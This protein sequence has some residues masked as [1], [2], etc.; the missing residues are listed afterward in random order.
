M[1][2]KK[3][4]QRKFIPPSP[5]ALESRLVS[6][7]TWEEWSWRSG[8]VNSA[9][10]Q[11]SIRDLELFTPNI[12][13]N[14]DLLECGKGLILRNHNFS[15]SSTWGN[16]RMTDWNLGGDSITDHV[17]KPKAVNLTNSLL[18]N[19]HLQIKLPVAKRWIKK[20]WR[21]AKD[22][23]AKCFTFIFCLFL[24]LFIF[25]LIFILH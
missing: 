20:S 21:G 15:I 9:V 10:I 19:E 17:P 12:Y 22:G 11:A 25:H 13:P 23:G 14:Y 7:L 5:W 4:L 24:F 8:R 3:K 6:A 2:W 18:I 16:I 1:S